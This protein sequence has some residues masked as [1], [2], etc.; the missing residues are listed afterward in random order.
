MEGTVGMKTSAIVVALGVACLASALDAQET[1]PRS[2]ISPER[3]GSFTGGAVE[4]VTIG[5]FYLRISNLNGE[6]ESGEDGDEDV[7][8]DEVWNDG[9]GFGFDLTWLLPVGRQIHIGP[10]ASA[11]FDL[12][13][14]NETVDV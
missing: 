8:W 13:S 10:F 4:E 2:V 9:L 12:F 11:T 1:D 14:G 7:D 5:S 6:L 3:H